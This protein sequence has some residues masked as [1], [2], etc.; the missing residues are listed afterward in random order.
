MKCQAQC[1]FAW[2]KNKCKQ[3]CLSVR[4]VVE[5]TLSLVSID[6]LFSHKRNKFTSKHHP[7]QT[8]L[9]AESPDL[10]KPKQNWIY[11]HFV[12][13]RFCV[14]LRRPHWFWN[15]LELFVMWILHPFV[16]VMFSTSTSWPFCLGDMSRLS[17]GH[18]PLFWKIFISVINK[19]W[20]N[21]VC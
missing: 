18:E 15:I 2:V 4:A 14:N 20:K 1:G 21:C 5:D 12:S 17:V 11:A 7:N 13:V 16:D 6:C 3:V 10:E 8:P 19:Y 9:R